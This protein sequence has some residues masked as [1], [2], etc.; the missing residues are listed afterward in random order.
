MLSTLNRTIQTL[1]ALAQVGSARAR[2]KHLVISGK[3]LNCGVCCTC[4]SLMHGN[5]W[6]R[7]SRTFETLKKK[8]PDYGYFV[9]TGRARSGELTFRCLKL[10]E[11]NLCSIY[12]SRPDFCAKYPTP[13]IHFMGGELL[14]GCGYRFETLPSFSRMLR[15]AASEEA[16]PKPPG[17]HNS[18]G[19]S[20]E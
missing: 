13:D 10:D 3:C 15:K 6:I 1:K 8:L 9:I 2:G 18:S 11:N 4:V 17:N 20:E 5:K 16:E 7:S 14:P 19:G 12:D